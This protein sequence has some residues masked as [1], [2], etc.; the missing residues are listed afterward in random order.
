[1]EHH[2]AFNKISTTFLKNLSIAFPAHDCFKDSLE[3]LREL[4][5]LNMTLA[6]ESFHKQLSQ[7]NLSHLIRQNND[8]FFLVE[9]PNSYLGQFF[10]INSIWSEISEKTKKILW[11]EVNKMLDLAEAAQGEIKQTM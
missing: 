7:K 11:R 1:M 2:Q 5:T 9:L 6:A 8:H 10:P 3:Q 4:N